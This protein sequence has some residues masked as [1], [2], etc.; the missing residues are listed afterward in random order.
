[1][2]RPRSPEQ[3]AGSVHPLLVTTHGIRLRKNRTYAI[4]LS[5]FPGIGTVGN[6]C[7]LAPGPVGDSY[8]RGQGFFEDVPTNGP[9]FLPLPGG[10]PT[11][12]EDLPFRTL[13]RPPSH[14]RSP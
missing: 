11:D 5:A 7:G 3:T 10:L 4:E 12:Q 2:P 6:T 1:M 13:V 9:G 14:R 8:S